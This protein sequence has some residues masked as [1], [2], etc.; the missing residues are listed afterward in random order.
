MSNTLQFTAISGVN[1][2]D[3][4]CYILEIDEAK[5]LLDCGS[6]E[7]Y[8]GETLAQLQRVARQVDAVLLSH[9]DAAHLGAYPLAFSRYGMT[10][11]AYATQAAHLMGRLCMQDV[12]RSLKAREEFVLFDERDVDA[13]FENITPLQYSQP[14]SLS[15]K[16]SDIVITA[17]AAGHTIGGAIWTISNGAEVVLYAIDFNQMNEKHLNR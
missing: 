15:G 13:A 9:P 17:H 8:S 7:D 11:P 3:A 1:S 14:K 6:Y 12:V 4:V 16:H 10:C 5:I 2:E